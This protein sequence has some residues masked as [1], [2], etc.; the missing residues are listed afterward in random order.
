MK[1]QCLCG[2]IVFEVLEEKLRLYQCHCSLCRKQCGTAS[3]FGSIVASEKLRWIAGEEKLSTYALKTGFR[4]NFCET[5]GSPVPNQIRDLSYHW[6]PAGLLEDGAD[7]EVVVHIW[8]GSKAPWE[9][10]P[11]GCKQYETFP[12]FKEFYSVLHPEEYD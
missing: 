4:S 1:G 2:S 12:E 9:T 8:V 10:I 7:L 5:C 3:N 6:I 11:A